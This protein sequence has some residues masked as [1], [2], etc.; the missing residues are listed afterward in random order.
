MDTSR[1]RKLLIAIGVVVF[2]VVIVLVWY[3]FYAK[4]VINPTLSET[5]NPL[6][7]IKTPP[8]FQF[9]SWGNDEEP[10]TITEVI[11]PLKNPL[12]QIWDR[13]STGQTFIIE[14]I[15]QEGTTTVQQGTST[16]EVR[17]VTRATSTTLLFVDKTTD[18]FM[19][20]L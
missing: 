3:F 18:T 20:T 19:L 14:Q 7:Q 15:L 12:T 5:N 11:D 16:V 9:L 10:S 13:P 1:N 8:R 2:F 17:Q 4:P 6:P